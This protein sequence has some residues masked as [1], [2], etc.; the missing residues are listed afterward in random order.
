MASLTDQ[1][2][3]F[4]S[5][6]LTDRNATAAAIRAGYSKVSARCTSSRIMAKPKIKAHIAALDSKIKSKHVLSAIETLERISREAVD[7]ENR[8]RDRLK[9][10]ELLAK[11]HALLVERHEVGG[12]GDF[13][14]LTDDEIDAEIMALGEQRQAAKPTIN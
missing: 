10:L 4:C 2:Q 1:Q 8:P 14:P 12:P 13:A 9:A 5:E 7:V 3:L 6:Y 11:H